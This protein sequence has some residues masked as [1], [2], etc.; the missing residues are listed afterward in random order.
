MATVFD[1]RPCQQLRTIN[2]EVAVLAAGSGNEEYP[3]SGRIVEGDPGIFE[4]MFPGGEKYVLPQEGTISYQ[5]VSTE[6][7]PWGK[8]VV[9]VQGMVFT[10]VPTNPVRLIP[11]GG[12]LNVVQTMWAFGIKDV[13]A[14]FSLGDGYRADALAGS[15]KERMSLYLL[16]ATRTSM[17]VAWRGQAGTKVL[18]RKGETYPLSAETIGL[19]E[20]AKPMVQMLCSIRSP[21]LPMAVALSKSQARYKTFMPHKDLIL[22]EGSRD[23]MMEVMFQ[24]NLIQMNALEAAAFVR[25]DRFDYSR[26]MHKIQKGLAAHAHAIVTLGERGAVLIP[27]VGD[28]TFVPAILLPQER[29]KDTCGPGDVLHASY[30]RWR[31]LSGPGA[32]TPLQSLKLAIAAAYTAIQYERPWYSIPLREVQSKV[33]DHVRTSEEWPPP[34]LMEGVQGEFLCK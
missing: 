3:I 19:L 20:D 16:P 7:M 23:Q 28:P 1:I 30:V 32:L 17:T 33:L 34:F 10:I 14:I 22:D 9:R 12:A 18:C 26:D 11:A 24:S 5:G 8:F 31:Y 13:G 21:D 6:E 29:V 15:I 4:T 2:G 27:A 25:Q